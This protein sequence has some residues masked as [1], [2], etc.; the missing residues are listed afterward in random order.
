MGKLI[1]LDAVTRWEA[2]SNENDPPRPA[3]VRAGNRGGAGPSPVNR[4]KEAQDDELAK[5]NAL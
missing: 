3:A 1:V 5:D 4:A 2:Q